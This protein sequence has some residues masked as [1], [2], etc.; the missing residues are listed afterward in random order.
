MIKQEC[1]KLESVKYN[2]KELLD[3]FIKLNI[4]KKLNELGKMNCR[5]LKKY[6]FKK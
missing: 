3:F 6:H 5:K 1:K 4:N 2:I